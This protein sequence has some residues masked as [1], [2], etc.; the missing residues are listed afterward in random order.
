MYLYTYVDPSAPTNVRATALT[1][2]SVEVKWDQSSG[3]TG[4]L[5]SYTTASSNTSVTVNDGSTSY[6]FTNL[7]QNTKFTITVQANGG[8]NRMS[9]KSDEVAVMTY[10]DGK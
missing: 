7:K 10:S 8:D 4:Y 2:Y 3:A 1:P 6:T 5:I 9:V